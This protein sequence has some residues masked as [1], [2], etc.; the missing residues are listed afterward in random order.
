MAVPLPRDEQARL[1]ALHELEILD[2]PPEQLYDDVAKLA[3]AICET[4]I[5]VINLIDADR[6]W[7]K[8]LVG[9]ESSEAPREISFCA[10]TILEEDGLLVVPDTRSDADWNENPMV[11]GDPGLRFY[12]G[13][14]I[15]NDE[16]HAL[17][18]V[19][20]ADT[21][22]PRELD[23]RSLQALRVLARQ[24]AA[25]LKLRRRSAELAHANEQLRE[26]AVTD[27]LTGLAN[28]AMLEQTILLELRRRR[29][30]GDHLG[31]L[32]CDLDGFKQVND[33]FG[34]HIGDELLKLVAGRLAGVARA[35]DL[36]AR[37]AGDEFVVLC[38][39]LED[40]ADLARI[41]ERF[42]EAVCTPARLGAVELAPVLS[43]G[44]AAAGDGDDVEDLLQRADAAM[45]VRKRA[46]AALA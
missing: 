29:R 7:G 33:R 6:Q 23:P 15:V 35:G 3:A 27:A 14:A 11:A 28:R 44:T 38:P 30:S 9:L 18:T 4:P 36:V 41:A 2:T 10:R 17:G 19:C 16:G 45:Y 42:A 1:A 24:T 26:L 5:A 39:G 32:F 12:A 37:F 22:G 21:R 43:I 40:A 13:A 31:L 46:A 8:A 20:V 25:H 34:H